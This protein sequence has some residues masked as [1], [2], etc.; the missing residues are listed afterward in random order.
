MHFALLLVEMGGILD[1][2]EVLSVFLHSY[3]ETNYVEK[4]LL[5]FCPLNIS[6]FEDPKSVNYLYFRSSLTLTLKMTSV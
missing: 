6:A 4:H 5:T 2:D 3:T 1:S